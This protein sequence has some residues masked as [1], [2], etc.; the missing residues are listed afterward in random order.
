MVSEDGKTGWHRTIAEGWRRLWPLTHSDLSRT[1]DDL[2]RDA[3]AIESGWL[4]KQVLVSMYVF[5]QSS[6]ISFTPPLGCVYTTR[7]CS[8]HYILIVPY[9]GAEISLLRLLCFNQLM[10]DMWG[11]NFAD[12]TW[13]SRGYVRLIMH[14]LAL[15]NS[16]FIRTDAALI[17]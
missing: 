11:D 2:R 8:V 16:T 10:G 7:W 17:K 6:L 15:G 12:L 9:L 3:D 14:P 4:Y 5:E 1:G 13:C